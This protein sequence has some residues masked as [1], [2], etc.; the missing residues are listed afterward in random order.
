MKMSWCRVFVCQSYLAT[1]WIFRSRCC[2]LKN[3]C[4]GSKM[5]SLLGVINHS[6]LN[7]FL[8]IK[9]LMQEWLIQLHKRDLKGMHQEWNYTNAIDAVRI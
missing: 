7:V 4:I 5:T 8:R 2:S 1:L 3:Y 6:V 9:L